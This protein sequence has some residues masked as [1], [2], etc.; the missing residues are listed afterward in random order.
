VELFVGGK[1]SAG[2]EVVT[3][4]AKYGIRVTGLVSK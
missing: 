4:G 1:L 2:G 3:V